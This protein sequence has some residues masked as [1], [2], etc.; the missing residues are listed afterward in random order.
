[1]SPSSK[2]KQN[3]RRHT[4]RVLGSERL[5]RREVLAANSFGAVVAA[6]PPEDVAGNNNQVGE[7]AQVCIQDAQQAAQQIQQ[8]FQQQ[9]QDQLQSKVQQLTQQQLKLQSRLQAKARIQQQLQSQEQL[10][11]LQKTQL[12]LQDQVQL[13]EQ[14]QLKVQEQTQDQAQDKAQDQSQDQVK[15]QVQLK[16]QDQEQACTQI[17][18]QPSGIRLRA[19]EPKIA[20]V[21]VAGEL[22]AQET[23][24][25]LHMRE[26]EKLARDVYQAMYD[27][28]GVAIF[29]NIAASEQQHMDAVGVLIERYELD[30]PVAGKADGIFE[31]P[32]L[33]IL[34]NELIA[35]GQKSL[36]A[37]FGVGISIE[38]LDIADLEKAIAVTDN[39]DIARVYGNLLSGSEHHLAAFSAALAGTTPVNPGNQ[40]ENHGGNQTADPIVNQVRQRQAAQRNRQAQQRKLQEQQEPQEQGAQLTQRARDRVFDR[41]RLFR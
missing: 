28:Y 12:E 25:L 7:T 18:G 20:Q 8:Q 1:M 36:E 6:G 9:V 15:D 17:E 31:D 37:A 11:T 16:E 32:A 39:V 30:D 22:D 38:T 23:T 5:E 13:Q 35:E 33:Q 24:D 21:A 14:E 27:L 34:Y 3:G 26:E 41:V 29:S 40:G 2:R 10:Q 19:A 4:H